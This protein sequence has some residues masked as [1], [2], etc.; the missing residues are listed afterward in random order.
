MYVPPV[1]TEFRII[2][3]YLRCRSGAFVDK[4][5]RLLDFQE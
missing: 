3:D 5:N 2:V 1:K 4:P